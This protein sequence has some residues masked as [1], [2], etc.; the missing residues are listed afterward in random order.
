M[1]GS[2]PFI[3]P[4]G[5]EYRALVHALLRLCHQRSQRK[6]ES[7]KISVGHGPAHIVEICSSETPPR[8]FEQINFHTGTRGCLHCQVPDYDTE[9]PTRPAL[10]GRLSWT[11]TAGCVAGVLPQT[12]ETRLQVQQYA[13]DHHGTKDRLILRDAPARDHHGTKDRL[14][15]RDAPG[16]NSPKLNCSKSL[17]LNTSSGSQT[18]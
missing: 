12:L 15:L 3:S 7:S 11:A 9:S 8:S 6:T 14:I 13:R 2:L 5:R 10:I 4:S 1:C 16:A 18:L 17:N